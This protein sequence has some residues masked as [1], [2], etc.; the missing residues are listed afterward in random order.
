MKQVNSSLEMHLNTA[1]N[2]MS[3]DLY[4][5]VLFNGNRYRWADTDKD[6][7]YAGQVYEHDALLIKRQQVKLN[8]RVVVD[9]MS[10][11]IYA[12]KR[13]TLEGK[14]L[15]QAVHDGDLDKAKLYL[16]RCFFRNGSIIGAID[17]FGGGVEV[18]QA[19]GIKLELTVK[20]KTQGLNM[21]FPIRRY[22]PQGSY[23]T[24]S[25]GVTTSKKTDEGAVIAP[26]VPLKEVLL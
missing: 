8:D 19:G 26:F 18:K 7:V 20:A 10:V 11:T 9:S 14:P 13:D 24:N 17:L 12:N 25:E 4:D 2:L 16:K 1:K 21:G 6:I 5:F 15:F 3:C 22:Y 23:T